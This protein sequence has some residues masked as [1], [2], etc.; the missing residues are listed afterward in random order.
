MR[1]FI[2][3]SFLLVI[4]FLA[5]LPAFAQN[6]YHDNSSANVTVSCVRGQGDAAAGIR[7]AIRIVQTSIV[8]EEQLY[9]NSFDIW[10]GS[11]AGTCTVQDGNRHVVRNPE[12]AQHADTGDTLLFVIEGVGGKT[13]ILRL[14]AVEYPRQR[15]LLRRQGQGSRLIDAG[16]DT[17]WQP[18]HI[19]D[20]NQWGIPRRC[21]RNARPVNGF[22]GVTLVNVGKIPI[23]Q[24]CNQVRPY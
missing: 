23:G 24:G 19:Y 21:L 2:F 1:G 6:S 5:N 10:S 7:D 11:R 17:A 8:N 12:I 9:R 13:W 16:F 4:G 3:T 14:Q 15:Y 22:A 20:A 18:T